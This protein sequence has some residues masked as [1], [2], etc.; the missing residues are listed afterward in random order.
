MMTGS[1]FFELLQLQLS[2]CMKWSNSLV[3]SAAENVNICIFLKQNVVILI[4]SENRF[5]MPQLRCAAGDI[6]ALTHLTT[7]T[8]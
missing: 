4:F 1:F 2:T 3:F 7:R 8:I 5:V 6:A